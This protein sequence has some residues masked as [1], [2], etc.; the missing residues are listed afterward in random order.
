VKIDEA[1]VRHVAR[2]AKLELSADEVARMAHDLDSILEYVEL[3]RAVDTTD[4]PPTTNP[5]ELATPLREDRAEAPLP[6]DEAVRSAPA[7]DV[8]AFLVPKVL[9]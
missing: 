9:D 3:L 2:L 5:L 6:V 7:H 4:V 8:G 1:Q